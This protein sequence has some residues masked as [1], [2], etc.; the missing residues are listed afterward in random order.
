MRRITVIMFTVLLWA[1]AAY[2]N[3]VISLNFESWGSVLP[4][5]S[6]GVVEVA[7][8]NDTWL[9]GNP[10]PNPMIDINDDTNTTTTVD[11]S[12]VSGTWGIYLNNDTGDDTAGT[13]NV[14]MMK[15]YLDKHAPEQTAFT[16]TEIPYDYY[17][18]YV[19]VMSD[20]ANRTGNVTDG[21]TTYYFLTDPASVHFTGSPGSADYVEF[22]EIT[23][24]ESGDAVLSNYTVFRT[25]S[26]DTLTI[27]CTVNN[28]GGIAGFQIVEVGPPTGPGTPVVTPDNGDDTV[29]NLVDADPG[30]GV[31]WQIQDVTLHFIAAKDPDEQHEPQYKINPDILYHNI[32][33]QTGAPEDPNLYLYDSIA[34]NIVDPYTHDP[35]VSYGP[36]PNNLLSQ[37]TTY[38]WQVEEVLDNGAGGY[39]AGDPNNIVGPVW[40][41]T[42]ASATPEILSISDHQLTDVNGDTALTIETGA[43]ANQYRWFKVVGEQDSDENAEV[44]DIK[45]A[46]G[47]LYSGTQTKTLAIAG[48]ASDGSDD[49]RYYAIAYNGDPEDIGIP[50][51]PSDVRWIWYPRETNRY[52]FEEIAYTVEGS[53]FIADM[54]GTSD[55]QL[56]SD[57]GTPDVPSIDPTNPDAPG[58][59][60]SQSL[61]F[62]NPNTNTDPNH[63]D[64]QYARISDPLFC[65]YKD[66]TISAWIYHKG[67]GW[68]RILSVGSTDGSGTNGVNTMYFTP[69]G[70]SNSG[71]LMLNV[72]G[73]SVTA[74][75]GSVPENEWAYVT[76]TLSGDVGK[77]FVNGE[78]VATNNNLTNDPVANAPAGNIML[79]RSQWWNY[80]SLFN[81]YIADLRIWNYGLTNEEVALAY[82]SDDTHAAYVCDDEHYNLPYDLNGNCEVDLG[83]LAVFAGRWLDNYR[84]Y[85][86]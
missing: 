82:L 36:L 32:W 8:W 55:I 42:T 2:A 63:A 13:R 10:A 70:N 7:N 6:A 62:N 58:L 68:Q 44:D 60:G 27:S 86:D 3:G 25:L 5:R 67:G 78:W 38:E 66:I 21:T 15:G 34:A 9:E 46:D 72:N 35:N 4:D 75:A 47:S 28:G 1:G 18:V 80:D 19:Y 33:L 39:P 85:P 73:Q 83:D 56:T 24:T 17:D 54:I 22:K 30:E 84:I 20:V 76:A 49:A 61:Y 57:D 11:V 31:D 65:G 37:G 59:V 16:V 77:L 64:G 43:V 14:A 52:T 79:G 50:S 81:G 12:W 26:G 69:S 48:M 51:P 40:S 53:D 71:Q 74:P 45:L 23:A 41:F 29:G